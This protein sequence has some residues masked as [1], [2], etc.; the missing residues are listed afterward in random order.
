MKLSRFLTILVLITVTS[1]FY[2]HQQI[3]L[4][5][6]SY[7]IQLN[8]HKVD[9]L[10]DQNRI[11]KYNVIALK[12][13]VNLENQLVA[14][15]VKLVLPERWQVVRIAGSRIEKEAL[16]GK[17]PLPLLFSFLRF[18]ALNREAQAKPID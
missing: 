1:L 6:Q 15:D 9:D 7:I 3:E 16:S 13:P 12:A 10:L 8:Q 4:I 2:V 18:F 14:N 17:K 11:L 5:K